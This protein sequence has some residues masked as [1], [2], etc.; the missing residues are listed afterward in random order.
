MWGR[1]GREREQIPNNK[2]HDKSK[3]ASQLADNIMPRSLILS[4]NNDENVEV[5]KDVSELC[6]PRINDKV[7]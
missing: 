7:L 2:W 6:A 5:M 3:S 1:G 4:S